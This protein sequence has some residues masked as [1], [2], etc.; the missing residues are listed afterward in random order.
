MRIN[1]KEYDIGKA[2]KGNG[3][4]VYNRAEEERGDY[5]TIAH[6]SEEGK[7]TYYEELPAEVKKIIEN[8]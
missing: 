5:K 3:V 6:I 8:T 1:G 2:C 4:T 7:I